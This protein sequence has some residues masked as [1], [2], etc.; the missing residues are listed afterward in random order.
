M[1]CDIHLLLSSLEAPR[2]APWVMQGLGATWEHLCLV[3]GASGSRGQL[4]QHKEAVGGSP[5][6][7]MMH[8]LHSTGPIRGRETLERPPGA[9][10]QAKAPGRECPSSKPRLLCGEVSWSPLWG[11]RWHCCSPASTAGREVALRGP[12]HLGRAGSRSSAWG[13][14]DLSLPLQHSLSVLMERMYSATPHFVRC[15]KP[16]SRKEPG[17]ADSQVLLQQ[18]RVGPFHCKAG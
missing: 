2:H 3:P 8:L 6:P 5:V 7:G 11:G 13:D 14:A 9:P 18:V 17:V 10:V 4:Q 16:N 12:R 1:S 15:V